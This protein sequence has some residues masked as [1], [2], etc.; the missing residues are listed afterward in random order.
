MNIALDYDDTWTASPGMW[1]E[2][3]SLAMSYGHRIK[4]VTFRPPDMPV[5]TDFYNM[6]SRAVPVY[7]TAGISKR[8]YMEDQGIPIAI[9]IDDKPELIVKP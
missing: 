4:I 8:Q 5:P 6:F 2:F 7:Y 3:V 9:W 1:E